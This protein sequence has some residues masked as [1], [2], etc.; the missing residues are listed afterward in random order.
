MAKKS[1]PL[2]FSAA[3]LATARNMLQNLKSKLKGLAELEKLI[4]LVENRS[5]VIAERQRTLDALNAEIKKRENAT[6]EAAEAAGERKAAEIVAKARKQAEDIL[7]DCAAKRDAIT[8]E[9]EV[10]EGDLAAL[11]ERIEA[12]RDTVRKVLTAA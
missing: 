12:A 10:R 6:L 2:D 3:D 8:A 1:A 11:N 9:V 7:A 5:Q 4:R